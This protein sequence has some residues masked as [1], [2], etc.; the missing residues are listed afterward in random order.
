LVKTALREERSTLNK[1]D[2][3]DACPC[4]DPET[5]FSGFDKEAIKGV[6]VDDNY[7]EITLRTCKKCGR[8]WLHY[9]IEYEYLTA[10]GRM[11]TGVIAPKDVRGLTA[12]NA[13]DQFEKMD[14]YFRGGSAFGPKLLRTTGSLRPWLMPFGR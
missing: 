5:H 13:V 7:G 14:W 2:S 12:E 4:L 10:S 9:F 1:S 6:G 3:K 8:Q 11:F